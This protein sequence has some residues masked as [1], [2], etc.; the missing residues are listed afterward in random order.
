MHKKLF[1]ISLGIFFLFTAKSFC[2]DLSFSYNTG[3]FDQVPEPRLRYPIND[4]AILAGNGPLIFKW[5]N[6]YSDVRSFIFRIYKG[7][8]MYENNLILRKELP[9]DASSVEIESGLFS[10]GQVYTW[11]LV[12][13]S[14]TGRKSDKSF[15]SFK[16]IKK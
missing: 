3:Y 15:N 11:S 8:N 5:W 10:D 9:A 1:V 14:L 6:D 12:R 2:G 4:T 16:V 13:V 7:Y